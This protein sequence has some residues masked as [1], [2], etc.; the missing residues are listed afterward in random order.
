MVIATSPAARSSST[1][2]RA[3][4]AAAYAAPAMTMAGIRKTRGKKNRI[5]R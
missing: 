2:N 1:P 4:H 3:R 5:M